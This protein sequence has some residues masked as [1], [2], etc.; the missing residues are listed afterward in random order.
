MDMSHRL[1]R[2]ESHSKDIPDFEKFKHEPYAPDNLDRV[3]FGVGHP[4]SNDYILLG[5]FTVMKK[6]FAQIVGYSL[7]NDW[8][9]RGIGEEFF[10]YNLKR[11]AKKNITE[12][13]SDPMGRN[14]KSERLWNNLKK[15]SDVRVERVKVNDRTFDKVSL[16]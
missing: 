6:P 5:V 12:L 15:R 3:E 1:H 7:Y 11:L 4:S 8:L 2:F 14:K 9:N 13:Y 10:V 16:I